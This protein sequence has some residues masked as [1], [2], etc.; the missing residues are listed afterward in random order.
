M[1]AIKADRYIIKNATALVEVAD[2]RAACEKLLS[3][4]QTLGGYVGGYNETV[5]GLG[6]RSV[7]MQVRVPTE[8]FDE[9]LG[10]L[11]PLGKVLQKQVTT[12][13]VSEEYV[14]T[15]ARARNLKATEERLLD[16]LTR[17]GKLDD[18]LRIEQEVTRVREQIE[19]LEGRLRFLNDRIQYSTIGIT[20]SEAPKAEPIVP[21][22][23]FSTAKVFTEAA[24]SLAE[25][26]Q[27]IWLRVIWYAVW[28]VVWLPCLVILW[29]VAR[30][31]RKSLGW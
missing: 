10:E 8:R 31:V 24:R 15:D 16:H 12:Q 4:I 7:V 30:R 1:S 27:H 23:T 17:S 21:A 18:I 11:E 22:Q 25:F 2:S 3:A 14:D 19:R 13:D 26:G 9:T 29:L 5:D 28:S 6:R 20:L